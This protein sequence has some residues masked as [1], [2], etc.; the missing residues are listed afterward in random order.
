MLVLEIVT[1]SPGL[2]ENSPFFRK[3]ISLFPMK[4]HSAS[5]TQHYYNLHNY[6]YT[7]DQLTFIREREIFAK[8]TRTSLS[9]IFLAA[10]QPLSC[11]CNS[12]VF[13][14]INRQLSLK[15]PLEKKSKFFLFPTIQVWKRKGKLNKSYCVQVSDNSLHQTTVCSFQGLPPRHQ[16][17]GLVSNTSCWTRQTRVSGQ[18]LARKAWHTANYNCNNKRWN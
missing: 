6:I 18:G 9:W 7:V 14:F 8:F 15:F 12:K 1:C 5:E 16:T 3:T 17:W 2:R 13:S 4:W 11:V 10:N